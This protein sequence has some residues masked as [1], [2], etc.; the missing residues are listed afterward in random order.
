MPRC[1]SARFGEAARFGEIFDRHAATLLR[2]LVRRVGPEVGEGLLGD[3]FR[4]AFERRALFDP[5]RSSARPWLYGIATNLLLKHHRDEARRGPY[6][7]TN[8][9]GW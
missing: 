1:W 8:A 6:G 4:V 5:A 7:I 9:L 2:F 3:V